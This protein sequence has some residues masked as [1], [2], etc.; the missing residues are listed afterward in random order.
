VAPH[1]TNGRLTLNRTRACF[2]FPALFV[3]AARGLLKK[4]SK[5]FL[6]KRD[7]SP[8]LP[9]AI[10]LGKSKDVKRNRSYCRLHV[11]H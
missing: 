8:E 9:N 2:F 10:Q 11:F 3:K 6:A 4:R 7:D 1:N 5:I